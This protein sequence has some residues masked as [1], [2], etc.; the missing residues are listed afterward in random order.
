MAFIQGLTKGI[1]Y[2]YPARPWIL[3]QMS[4]QGERPG[5]NNLLKLVTIHPKTTSDGS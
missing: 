4:L 2:C 5:Y 3:Q 1:K